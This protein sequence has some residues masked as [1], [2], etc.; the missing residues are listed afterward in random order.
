[1]D[2]VNQ[3]YKQCEE[4]IKVHSKS[5][6]KAFSLLPPLKKK[7]VWAVYTFCRTVD[8]IVDEGTN[9][10]EELQLFEEKFYYFLKGSNPDDHF[11]WIALRD[12]FQR[13]EMD[14]IPFQEMIEGQRMD[15][16][17]KRYQDLGE[18]LNYSYH[19]ASTVGL[20]LLPILAPSK[21]K[22]L[23]HSAI[24]LGIAMQLTNILRDIGED[25]E[26]DR[27]YLPSE[28][29]ERF[30]YT[31]EDLK[32]CEISDK[33]I[34]VWESL[35]FE[36]EAYYEEAMDDLDLYPLHSR[37]P[38]KAAALFYKAILNTVRANHYAVFNHRNYV[39]SEE[40]QLIMAKM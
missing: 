5:F 29:M 18:V 30:Q 22:Q 39:T 19:V 15:L 8:D 2:N 32:N 6:Y 7:A 34:S 40:K 13:Y 31:E 28:T 25:L 10:Q 23:R 4:V 24:S 20:M 17:K 9:P 38:V 27:I 16:T 37:R 3:A 36:A 14:S 1:M 11:L 12:T 33:F 21:A 26:R 35:A